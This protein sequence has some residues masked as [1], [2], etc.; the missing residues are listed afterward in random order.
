[1]ESMSE[2][3]PMIGDELFV[4]AT[5]QTG[6]RDWSVKVSSL[7][8]E[9]R[10]MLHLRAESQVSAGDTLTVWVYDIHQTQ[11]TILV[12]NSEFGRKPIS[13]RMR[14]RYL[15]SIRC[16]Q[17]LLSFGLSQDPGD[18]EAISE[19]KGMF[20]RCLRKDQWD[21]FCVYNAFGSPAMR[22]ARQMAGELTVLA[23]AMRAR[24]VQTAEVALSRLHDLGLEPLLSRATEIISREAPSLSNARPLTKTGRQRSIVREQKQP[25]QKVLSEYSK[26]KLDRANLTHE[27]ILDILV[28]FLE[29]HG[30]SVE[31]SAYIDAFCRLKSGP[32]IFEAKS[33][34]L[35][36][37]AFP[38]SA[39]TEPAV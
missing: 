32:A 17:N 15:Q 14:P 4:E 27:R 9:W 37:R 12:S 23:R 7:P 6:E 39:C 21:W 10:C 11:K 24:D 29:A 22:L 26:E 25:E 30:H 35:E 8:H 18:A 33:I 28:K 19:V 3:I 36:N 34:T 38:G 1:M 31:Q 16:L 20:N 13:D 5:R 2:A